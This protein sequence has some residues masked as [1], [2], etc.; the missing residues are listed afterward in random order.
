MDVGRRPRLAH[1]FCVAA[2]LILQYAGPRTAAIAA[3]RVALVQRAP[4]SARARPTAMAEDGWGSRPLIAISAEYSQLC[5]AQFEVL[6]STIGASRCAVYF[7]REH[8]LTGALEFVPVAVYPQAQSVWV[9]GQ[10]GEPPT[11]GP[12][13]LPGGTAAPTLIPNYPFVRQVRARERSAAERHSGH[14]RLDLSPRTFEREEGVHGTTLRLCCSPVLLACAAKPRARCWT[15]APEAFAPPS[16]AAQPVQQHMRSHQ[17]ESAHGLTSVSTRPPAQS[18]PRPP[19]HAPASVR[20]HTQLPAIPAHSRR[21]LSA[22]AMH[23]W[24]TAS[25]TSTTTAVACSCRTGAGPSRS[26]LTASSLASSRSGA[27]IPK[28]PHSR[29]SQSTRG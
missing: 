11:V 23:R 8:P 7:R 2:C 3:S 29:A 24:R 9:V 4:A 28:C 17:H 10:N 20:T 16:C 19:S 26:R 14:T 13:E 1:C 22:R 21:S 27:R 12:R 6:A 18:G 15:P 25:P 5:Q